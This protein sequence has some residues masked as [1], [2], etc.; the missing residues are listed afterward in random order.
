[1]SRLL[2]PASTRMRVRSVRMNVEFPELLLAS[3]QTLTI[4]ASD[5]PYRHAN[6]CGGAAA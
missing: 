3:T 5:I 4:C 2:N 1:M 6:R